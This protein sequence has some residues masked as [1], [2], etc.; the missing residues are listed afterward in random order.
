MFFR[1]VR[2][3][4]K[5]VMQELQLR[6]SQKKIIPFVGAGL[7]I[8]IDLPSW[9]EL[10]GTLKELVSEEFWGIIDFDLES[11]DYLSAIDN[12]KKYSRSSEQVIQEKIADL[13]DI[14]YIEPKRICDN[15][16]KDLVK[17]AFSIYFTTNYD[18]LLEWHLPDANS[19]ASLTEYDSNTQRLFLDTKKNI[20]HLHGSVRNP[21]SIVISSE[22][23]KLLYE[24]I[25]YSDLMKPFSSTYS[26]LFLGFSF[27]DIFIQNILKEHKS[28]YQ[29]NHYL[30]IAK[31]SIDK[32]ILDELSSKFGIKIIEYDTSNSSH[33][34]EIRKILEEITQGPTEKLLSEDSKL[35]IQFEDLKMAETHES[36]LFFKKLELAN[37]K[38]ELRELSIL[39]YISAEK[40]IRES[41]KL[42]F[43]KTYI[44]EILVEVFLKYKEKYTVLYGVQKKDSNELLIAIHDDLRDINI[45]RY[46]NKDTFFPKDS[47]TQGMIHVLADDEEKDVWWGSERFGSTKQ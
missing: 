9:D 2:M 31:G 32:K 37:V 29:G 15:N 4:R 10:I 36:S 43:P 6:Y 40:F 19:F 30:I 28:I 34:F 13:Y 14:Q 11:G 18:K 44:D 17:D 27:N 45:E 47:E 41:V 33:I 25:R 26:F 12:I 23:Y 42:G 24:D 5:Q 35:G 21:S 20:F 8:P 38:T 7:S 1:R 16:Y 22:S 46:K 39:F 3:E